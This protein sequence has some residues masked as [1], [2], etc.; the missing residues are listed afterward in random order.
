MYFFKLNYIYNQFKTFNF[1]PKKQ[2][3]HRTLF[4]AQI[5]F[6]EILPKNN[7]QINNCNWPLYFDV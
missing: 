4:K 7:P 2:K 6:V 3:K 1:L 5:M